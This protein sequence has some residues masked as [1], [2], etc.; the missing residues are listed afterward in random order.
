MGG[1]TTFDPRMPHMPAVL[2]RAPET[3]QPATGCR[4]QAVG[5]RHR[6]DGPLIAART[7][8]RRAVLQTSHPG[9]VTPYGAE[10]V[11]PITCLP[12]SPYTQDAVSAINAV[13]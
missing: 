4:H 10:W 2:I 13:G 3:L 8:G 9:S 7:P 1:V 12:A 11:R 6:Q 5:R